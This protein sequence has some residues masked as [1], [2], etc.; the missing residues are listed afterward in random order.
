MTRFTSCACPVEDH[1]LLKSTSAVLTTTESGSHFIA[2]RTCVWLQS[3][4]EALARFFY[5][6]LLGRCLVLRKDFKQ[7]SASWTFAQL[8]MPFEVASE[9]DVLLVN[10]WCP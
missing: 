2:Q 5:G 9:P 4:R 3:A 6:Q 7:R 10:P 8:S 1:V